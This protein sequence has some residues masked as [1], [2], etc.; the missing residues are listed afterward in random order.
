LS[1]C[2]KQSLF[3]NIQ[4]SIDLSLFFDVFCFTKKEKRR[5]KWYWVIGKI[6]FHLE[7]L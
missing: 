7:Y 6:D 4:N 1:P 3:K 2:Q 5:N